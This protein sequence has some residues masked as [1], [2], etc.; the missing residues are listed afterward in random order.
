MVLHGVEDRD[1]DADG[2]VGVVAVGGGGGG[3]GRGV[4]AGEEGAGEVA[5]G[6]YD[7]GEV[8]AAVPEAVVGGLVAEDLGVGDLVRGQRFPGGG[9]G[10]GA[11]GELQA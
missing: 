8:V 11:G 2:A 5:D 4:A 7:Y 3:V 6:G 9:G 10:G 1:E